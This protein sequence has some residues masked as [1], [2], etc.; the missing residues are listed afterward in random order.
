MNDWRDQATEER[1]LAAYREADLPDAPARLWAMLERPPA[2]RGSARRAAQG[3]E[4]AR[5]LV[6]ALVFAVLAGSLALVAGS[7][8]KAPTPSTTAPPASSLVPATRFPSPGDVTS[9]TMGGFVPWSPQTLPP[10]AA[11]PTPTAPA[12]EARVCTAGELAVGRAFLEGATGSLAGGFSIWTTGTQPC[13]IE[14]APGVEVVDGNGRRLVGHQPA[15][16]NG[17]PGP[18]ALVPGR[19]LPVPGDD[20]PLGTATVFIQWWSW[21]KTAPKEPVS[22]RVSLLDGS[23]IGSTPVETYG[24]AP[25]CDTPG[26]A[27][28]ISVGPFEA[29][30]GP[31]PTEPP[32]IPASSLSGHLELPQHAVIGEPLHYLMIITNPTS[33]AIPLGPCP[34]YREQLTVAGRDVIEEHVLNCEGLPPLAPGATLRFEMVLEV[35]DDLRPTDRAGVIWELDPHFGSGHQGTTPRDKAVL[36]LVAP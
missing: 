22:L 15:D 26:Q 5:S 33:S 19:A 14:G 7:A 32:T 13:V 36:S 1:L 4:S 17:G 31:D 9:P 10:P 28:S 23:V 18:V 25:R 21:C 8:W 6:A 27:S 34:A 3:A 24:V 16:G 2:E 11:T 30:T 20:P 29:A 35:P 12:P